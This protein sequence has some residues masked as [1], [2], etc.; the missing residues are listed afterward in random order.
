MTLPPPTTTRASSQYWSASTMM[1]ALLNASGTPRA[2]FYRNRRSWR[3]IIFK[4]SSSTAEALCDKVLAKTTTLTVGYLKL[5]VFAMNYGSFWSIKEVCWWIPECPRNKKCIILQSSIPLKCHSSWLEPSAGILRHRQM[6]V[7]GTRSEN[8]NT[9]V[10][11]MCYLK[12]LRI[13]NRSRAYI[14]VTGETH[15]FG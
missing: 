12:W 8:Q 6:S 14:I 15:F 3:F 11:R 10:P 2:W 13:R 4:F 9:L 7:K 5:S 1:L